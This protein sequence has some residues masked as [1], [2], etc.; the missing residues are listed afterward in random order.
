MRVWT[1]ARAARPFTVLLAMLGAAGCGGSSGNS[2]CDE[3]K[4]I[5]GPGSNSG[6]AYLGQT[7]FSG[8][9]GSCPQ[10]FSNCVQGTCVYS[11]SSSDDICS[12]TCTT[13]ADCGS[14]YCSGGFCQPACA[15]HTY[16]DGTLC[17]SYGP[18]ST[19][20]TQCVQTGC[21]GP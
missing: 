2:D 6:P 9:Y 4:R 13:T 5:W 20:P 11:S 3:A 10:S 21:S 15:A 7:C 18:S 14:L 8:S 19:D 16:C 12:V 1:R 17:C